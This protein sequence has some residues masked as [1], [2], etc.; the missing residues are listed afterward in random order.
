MPELRFR[1]RKGRREHRMDISEA[2]KGPPGRKE[3]RKE[4][5]KRPLR[6]KAFSSYL[7][8]LAEVF[9]AFKRH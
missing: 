1:W 7:P 2:G 3:G 6:R 9:R 5:R 8:R 4:G